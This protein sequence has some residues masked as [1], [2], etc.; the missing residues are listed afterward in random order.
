MYSYIL[1][2]YLSFRRPSIRAC[3]ASN[4]IRAFGPIAHTADT[5]H[6]RCTP[7]QDVARLLLDQTSITDPSHLTEPPWQ[8]P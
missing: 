8:D 7:H 2:D 4:E 6:V 1:R 3:H 5:V